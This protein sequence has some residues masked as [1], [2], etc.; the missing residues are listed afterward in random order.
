MSRKNDQDSCAHGVA[1]IFRVCYITFTTACYVAW[2]LVLVE[3]TVVYSSIH[4]GHGLRPL[5]TIWLLL[6]WSAHLVVHGRWVG[7]AHYFLF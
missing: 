3:D 1:L 6:V 7:E 4:V 2:L 5:S